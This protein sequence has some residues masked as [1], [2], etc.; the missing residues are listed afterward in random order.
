[1]QLS[2]QT[3]HV[4]DKSAKS[5]WSDILGVICREKAII[6][7][8]AQS[9]LPYLFVAIAVG[10]IFGKKHVYV[11]DIHDLNEYGKKGSIRSRIRWAI[12]YCLE[13]IVAMLNVRLLTVSRGLSLIYYR[14]LRKSVSVVYNVSVHGVEGEGDFL[15]SMDSDCK[16]IIYFGLLKEDRVNLD[17]VE[18]LLATGRFSS[19]DVRGIQ[20]PYASIG[21]KNRVSQMISNGCLKVGAR[22][23]AHDLSF[24]RAYKFSWLCFESPAINIRYCMPNKLFQSLE[25]GLRCII[26]ENMREVDIVFGRGCMKY[27]DC[28]NGTTTRLCQFL[29]QD[30]YEIR[31]RIKQLQVKSRSKFLRACGF[32]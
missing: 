32:A 26:S 15:N 30:R 29:P 14:R 2:W 3:G 11:Y 13:R 19:F 28:I 25:S 24:L 10:F 12:F 31:E 17:A 21:F 7:F 18:K 23:E 8:H 27:Q 5:M 9:S 1:M 6:V 16:T 4:I 20:S 22:Y